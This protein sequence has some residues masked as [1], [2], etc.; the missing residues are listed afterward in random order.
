[1][2]GKPRSTKKPTRS[3]Q[4]QRAAL[5]ASRPVPV[6]P[7]AQGRDRYGIGVD[8]PVDT[9]ASAQRSARTLGENTR[10]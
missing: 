5:A 2:H 7:R 3:S 9:L 4:A 1:M 6:G 10:H 8:T